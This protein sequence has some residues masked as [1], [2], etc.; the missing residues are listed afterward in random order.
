MLDDASIAH[1]TALADV[2]CTEFGFHDAQGRSQRAGCLKALRDLERAGHFEL[3]VALTVATH[4]KTLYGQLLSRYP[5][6]PGV[7]ERNEENL[8]HQRVTEWAAELAH[9]VGAGARA[10]LWRVHKGVVGGSLWARLGLLGVGV[11]TVVLS[12]WKRPPPR[13]VRWLLLAVGWS[14]ATVLPVVNLLLIA[15]IL[16]L[17]LPDLGNLGGRVALDSA[18]LLMACLLA[19]GGGALLR[20]RGAP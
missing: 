17:G 3:P 5:P 18:G 4:L 8:R 6:L 7:G 16:L 20:L 12:P 2:L 14:T 13:P 9:G 11:V 15:A 1:R 19:E 10:A